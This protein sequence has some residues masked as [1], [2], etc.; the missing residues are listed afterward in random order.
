VT[1]NPGGFAPPS[2]PFSAAY[3]PARAYTPPPPPPPPRKLPGLAV[4][5]IVIGIVALLAA[6]VAGVVVVASKFG[7]FVSESPTESSSGA[8]VQGDPSGPLAV[9]PDDCAAECF[10]IGSVNLARPSAKEFDKVGLT[11]DNADSEPSATLNQAHTLEWRAWEIGNGGSANCFAANARLPVT[12]ELGDTE[13]PDRKMFHYKSTLS[14]D[15][16]GSTFTQRTRYFENSELAVA[17]MVALDE[18]IGGCDAYSITEW[19]YQT[20]WTV[21]RAPQLATPDNVAALGWVLSSAD[22]E[23]TYV[24]DIQRGNYVVRMILDSWDGLTEKQ[25][26]TLVTGAA[27]RVGE[28]DFDVA[29]Q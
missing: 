21:T 6:I 12:T 28:M 7:E 3:L 5:G 24:F 13:N 29:P 14:D 18:E 15:W 17:H 25:Y 16:G 26:R 20:D 9:A 19:D 11:Y 22:G 4:A 10:D 23:R 8:L 1:D 27:E 2:Q